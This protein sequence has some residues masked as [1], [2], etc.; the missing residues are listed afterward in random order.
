MPKT[1]AREMARL[2]RASRRPIAAP[3]SEIAL[4]LEQLGREAEAGGHVRLASA[5]AAVA[6]DA[7]T[8]MLAEPADAL[9]APARAPAL[10]GRS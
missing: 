9:D 6:A 2:A 1:Y 4:D 8:A 3:L 5:I 10:A 7:R